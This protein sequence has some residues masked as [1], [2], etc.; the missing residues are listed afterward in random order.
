MEQSE[1]LTFLGKS[2]EKDFVARI[3]SLSCG[4]ADVPL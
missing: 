4:H 3:E 2:S 1:V